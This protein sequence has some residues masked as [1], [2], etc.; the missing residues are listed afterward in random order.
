MKKIQ[1]LCEKALFSDFAWLHAYKYR[2]RYF[3]NIRGKIHLWLMWCKNYRNRS[4]ITKVIAKNLLPPF[5]WTTVYY[6]NY[7]EPCQR[8][9]CYRYRINTIK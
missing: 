8:V 1:R 9:I 2:V 4:R 7:N 5:L 6:D 3:A